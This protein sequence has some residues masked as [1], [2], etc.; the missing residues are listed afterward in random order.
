MT[1]PF[2]AVP[3][4]PDLAQDL[5]QRA[6]AANGNW[7]AARTTAAL[8]GQV[9][10]GLS[11]AL[12]TDRANTQVLQRIISAHGWPGLSLVGEEAARAALTL[13]LHAE[14]DPRAQDEF[15]RA[16]HEAAQHREA[17]PGQWARLYD[18]TL[19]RGGRP[20]VYGT[21][22]RLRPDGELELHPVQDREQLD[23]RRAQVGLRVYAEQFQLIR[24]RLFGKSNSLP[25]P[26]NEDDPVLAESGQ[27]R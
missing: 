4:R 1:T 17:T 23:S 6:K 19:A 24:E 3:Q 27:V 5:I 7:R 20:Q 12:I 26:E 2:Q 16:V 9:S 8:Q 15:L 21:Q 10:A 18:R 25:D 11:A 13:A 14:H 22:H